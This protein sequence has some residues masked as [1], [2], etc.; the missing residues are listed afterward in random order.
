[1]TVRGVLLD[2]DGVLVVSWK[3]LPG[4]PDALHRLRGA[5]LPIRLLTNTTSKTRAEV[6]G[7]LRAC[8]FELDDQEL[9]TASV[10]TSAYLGEHYTR[11]RCAVL[12]EGPLDDLEGVE[13]VDLS[14]SP[15]VVV[16]GSAGPM[17]DWQTMNLA[18]R[19]VANGAEL[20]AMHGTA[21]WQTRDGLCIDGGAYATALEHATGVTATT[22]GK[23]ARGMFDAA[24]AGLGI[25]PAEAVMVGDDLASD[26]LAAQ[27][28]GLT[29]VLV[30]TGKFRQALLDRSAE[31][32]DVVIDAV[33]ELPAFLEVV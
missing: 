9:L 32:P 33:T 12:N 31:Q 30:R 7:A 25:D 13:L 20:V 19:T 22:I 2:V 16:I 11:A 3:A 27:H 14:D 23:P 10:A 21:A 17:F 24:V 6:A 15:E 4:A 18:A 26:V 28:L 29:G 8:G 1:M 5:G